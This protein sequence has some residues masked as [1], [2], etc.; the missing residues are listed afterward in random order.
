DLNP[1]GQDRLV[2][3]L[4]HVEGGERDLGGTHEIQV[5]LSRDVDVHGVGGEEPR[6]EHGFL[7]NQHRGD[8]RLEPPGGQDVERVADQGELDVHDVTEQVNEPR[9]AGARGPFDVQDPEELAER[10]VIPRLE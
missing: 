5:V 2:E 10:D 6:P 1:D 9:A 7:P 8:D 3:D 4:A